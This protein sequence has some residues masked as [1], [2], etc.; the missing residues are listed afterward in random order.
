MKSKNLDLKLAALNLLLMTG[1]LFGQGTEK[2][3]LIR[4][5]DPQPPNVTELGKYAV[6]PTAEYTGVVPISIPLFEIS[7]KGKTL[8]FGLSYHASGIKV[9]QEETEV[10]LGWS[11]SGMYT[12]SRNVIGGIDERQGSSTYSGVYYHNPKTIQEL[13][14]E[15]NVPIVPNDQG[16]ILAKKNDL[17]ALALGNNDNH[18]DLYTFSTKSRS[19]KFLVKNMNEYYTIPYS[20]IKISRGTISSDSYRSYP[21]TIVDD[22][23]LNYLFNDRSY[24]IGDEINSGMTNY[25]TTNSWYISKITDNESGEFA[26]FQYMDNWIREYLNNEQVRIGYDFNGT[27]VLPMNGSSYNR[28]NNFIDN[29]SK[30]ITS[31]VHSNGQVLFEY[32]S[33]SKPAY[34]SP[35]KF[36]SKVKV[37]NINGELIKEVN[38]VYDSSTDRVKLS[39]VTVKNL[40]E[41]TSDQKY[42]FAYD[43]LPLPQKKSFSVDYWGYYNGSLSNTYIPPTT[44]RIKNVLSY[45]GSTPT[46]TFGSAD[47]TPN[48]QFTQG[49][50]LKRI[51]YPT[52][53]YTEFE[54]ENNKYIGKVTSTSNNY[55]SETVVG[56]GVDKKNEAVRTFTY[57]TSGSGESLEPA[58]IDITFNPPTPPYTEFSMHP[59]WVRVIDKTTNTQ[60]FEKWHDSDPNLPLR[61]VQTLNL[62]PGHN[63]E[64]RITVYGAS[65]PQSNYVTTNTSVNLTWKVITVSDGEKLGGGLR[66]KSIKSYS[67]GG[68]LLSNEYYKYGENENGL[69]IS[70]FDES[71]F[72]K[73]YQDQDYYTFF[74]TGGDS[75]SAATPGT[76]YWWDRKYFGISNYSSVATSGATIGYTKV[77]KYQQDV[78]S[79]DL[80]LSESEYTIP[81]EVSFSSYDFLNSQNYG[82][83]SFLLSEP[84]M[85]KRMDFR[86]YGSSYVPVKKENYTYTHDYQLYTSPLVFET[87]YYEWTMGLSKGTHF[88]SN[89]YVDYT[90]RQSSFQTSRR[91]PLQKIAKEYFYNADLS[92]KD[93]ISTEQNFEYNA[94]YADE[95]SKIRVASS[96]QSVENIQEFTYPDDVTSFAGFGIALSTD[97]QTGINAWKKGM[98]HFPNRSVRR[99]DYSGTVL[100]STNY[101]LAAP[102]NGKVFPSRSVEQR[103]STAFTDLVVNRYDVAGNPLEIRKKDGPLTVYLWGYGGRYPIAEIKNASYN[104]VL[105]VLNQVALDNLNVAS[106]S[107]AAIESAMNTL[108]NDPRLSKAMITS[109]TYK[110]LVGMTSKTDPRGVK[111]TYKYDGMQRL[112]AILDHLG[113][114]TKAIDYHYRPN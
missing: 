53:G 15:Y 86:K 106:V 68:N 20:S 40:D 112:Q 47:R 32:I 73:N 46:Y 28:S 61:V 10:G 85:K 26:N 35:R 16:V 99:K 107:D 58:V 87:N 27:E 43:P 82:S 70:F 79:S 52:K 111:E 91:K 93:S 5:T 42:A 71:I 30:L 75:G 14:N 37:L 44:I 51:T 49:E 78:V 17:R 109:Y 50:M 96:N 60:I 39:S 95:P 29:N 62:A 57:A 84:S 56:L 66:V 94:V 101:N 59:Q 33:V 12:I 41:G 64:L 65:V 36:L 83:L 102:Y 54:F 45:S 4:L 21:F 6:Y 11:L 90:F 92:L 69:G 113:H 67:P 81:R 89:Y 63:Y 25:A 38:F 77:R 8:P 48:I 80:I 2:G 13:M 74:E 7:L 24:S 18:S 88:A 31:I 72:Y 114:V 3:G 76:A 1:T 104:E 55:I 23:G 19:G 34:F 108:R 110:P 9:D 22:E 97:E 105:T 100:K 103:G 98:S